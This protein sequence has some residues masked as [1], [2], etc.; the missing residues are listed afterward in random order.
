MRRS[1]KFRL[2]PT[3]K[4]EAALAS[5]LEDTR[6]LYNATLEERREAWR[7]GRSDPLF[8]DD[9]TALIHVTARGYPCAVNNLAIHPLRRHRSHRLLT[10]TSPTTTGTT[11]TKA[12]QPNGCGAFPDRRHR[13]PHRRLHRHLQ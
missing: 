6:Q 5:C 3:S 11:P 10:G 1:Y 7:M 9:A 2:R 8:S 13:H 4:Q 12:P